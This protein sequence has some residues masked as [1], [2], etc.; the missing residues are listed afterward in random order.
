MRNW[1]FQLL[2]LIKLLV[3]NLTARAADE[4][5]KYSMGIGPNLTQMDVVDD[6]LGSS[7]GAAIW[8]SRTWGDN[9]RLDISFDYLDFKG[10]NSNYLGL[11]L[12]YG[13]EF[14]KNT[15]WPIYGMIGV[16]SGQANNIPRA[17]NPQQSTSHFFGRVGSDE[18][19]K[20]GNWSFGIL[21]DYL[22]VKLDSKPATQAQIGLP[23]ISLSYSSGFD[24]S[25]KKR[26]SSVITPPAQPQ[27]P[28]PKLPR[29]SIVPQPVIPIKVEKPKKI[30]KSLRIHFETAK[31]KILEIHYNAIDEFAKFLKENPEYYIRIEG[32]TDSVG[33]HDYNVKL[34][35]ARAT[36]V[37]NAL[38]I[39]GGINPSRF[40]AYGFGPDKP[41]YD[42]STDY[43]KYHNR[44]VTA[45][46]FMDQ[47]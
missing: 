18:L 21:Y 36:S 28:G 29:E 23:M 34:S 37:R 39:R 17:I 14:F 42:N 38:I 30:I 25:N 5:W 40:K 33:K 45:V 11:S 47:N 8:A 26:A 24:N 19:F 6:E 27:A 16:G 41:I 12:G 10:R 1:N 15:K 46:L 44:R 22:F 20:V 9:N 2:L 7:Y 35:K 31:F 32:H 13:L 43:G 3:F 4:N